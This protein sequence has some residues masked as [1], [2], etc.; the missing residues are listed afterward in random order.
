MPLVSAVFCGVCVPPGI[1]YWSQ[2]APELPKDVKCLLVW[3]AV[4][5]TLIIAALA[6]YIF[7]RIRRSVSLGN[8]LLLL[9]VSYWFLP[10]Q[11][12]NAAIEGN[13]FEE[14]FFG[15]PVGLLLFSWPAWA[16]MVARRYGAAHPRLTTYLFLIAGGM[17]LAAIICHA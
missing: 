14:L 17:Q 9:L 10:M 1:L 6:Y 11:V 16:A 2:G 15:T 12:L 7:T 5:A 8:V 4:A 3:L 13:I